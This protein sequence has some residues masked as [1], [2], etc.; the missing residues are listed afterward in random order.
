MSVLLTDE[1][2]VALIMIMR[3]SVSFR[4]FADGERVKGRQHD[5][6]SFDVGSDSSIPVFPADLTDTWR[7]LSEIK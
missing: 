4:S 7:V 3:T 2:E 1:I 6:E 5:D